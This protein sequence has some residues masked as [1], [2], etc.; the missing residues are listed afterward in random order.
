MADRP[1]F[2][3]QRIPV[4]TGAKPESGNHDSHWRG[5]I[6]DPWHQV[7]RIVLLAHP[8]VWIAWLIPQFR[9]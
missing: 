4:G 7:F 9:G 5:P 6:A 1:G 8:Q 3:L 2:S